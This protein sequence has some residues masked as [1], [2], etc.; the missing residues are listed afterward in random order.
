MTADLI[1]QQPEALAAVQNSP[2]ARPS[3]MEMLNAS[4]ERSHRAA[5]NRHAKMYMVSHA[6]ANEQLTQPTAEAYRDSLMSKP[7]EAITW[8][9]L[10]A[11]AL[12]GP[13]FATQKWE[14]LLQTALQDI[15]SSHRSASAVIEG[16]GTPWERAQFIALYDEL[17]ADWHPRT[18][19][20]RTLL[21]QAAIAHSMY[22]HWIEKLVASGDEQDLERQAQRMDTA[23]KMAD[24][25]QRV[26]MRCVKALG[27]LRKPTMVVQRAHQ[28]NVGGTQ[29][30]CQ[31]NAETAVSGQIHAIPGH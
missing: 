11:L 22:L 1:P 6:E 5:V 28:V 30:L 17:A 21:Q 14:I 19:I 24:R 23:V 16:D 13:G 25:F 10:H 20:E 9:D 15:R 8:Q 7:A 18:G 27:D 2:L 3:D 4:M 26:L 31:V 12:A 29:N